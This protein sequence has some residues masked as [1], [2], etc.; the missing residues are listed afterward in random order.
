M[1]MNQFLSVSITT[2]SKGFGG[3]VHTQSQIISNE[4][5]EFIS[6]TLG[7]FEFSFEGKKLKISSSSGMIKGEVIGHEVSEDQ[8]ISYKMKVETLPTNALLVTMTDSF[9]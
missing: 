3:G 6:L 1:E 9:K 8:L 2:H 7:N 4:N 5:T